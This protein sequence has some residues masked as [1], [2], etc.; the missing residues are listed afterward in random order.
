MRAHLQ[1]CLKRWNEIP[2]AFWVSLL[3]LRLLGYLD[4][5]LFLRTPGLLMNHWPQAKPRREKHFLELNWLE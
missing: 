1:R 3:S 5:T 4:E 2:P